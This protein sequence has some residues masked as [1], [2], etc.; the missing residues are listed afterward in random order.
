[1]P[2]RRY[3]RSKGNSGSGKDGA[4]AKK[5]ALATSMAWAGTGIKVNTLTGE[6]AFDPTVPIDQPGEEGDDALIWADVPEALRKRLMQKPQQVTEDCLMCNAKGILRLYEN[7][8][9]QHVIKQQLRGEQL[10]SL[11]RRQ[12]AYRDEGADSELRATSGKLA[13]SSFLGQDPTGE[14]PIPDSLWEDEDELSEKGALLKDVQDTV[15]NYLR[16]HLTRI[17]SKDVLARVQAQEEMYRNFP[18]MKEG[19]HNNRMPWSEYKQL[20]TY[21]LPRDTG[22]YVLAKVLTMV[23]EDAESAQSWAQRMHK[24]RRRVSKRMQTNLSDACYRELLFQGLTKKEQGELVK[25]QI[26]R[27]QLH[28]HEV[29]D[30]VMA[31]WS[32]LGTY[33]LAEI[34][35]VGEDGKIDVRYASAYE[36]VELGLE[37]DDIRSIGK[38]LA[39]ARAMNT[40]RSAPWVML[41]K[42]VYNDIGPQPNYIARTRRGAHLLFTHEQALLLGIEILLHSLP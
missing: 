7:D 31:N 30:Q 15:W 24:G 16:V 5:P 26:Q 35:A 39:K 21:L 9:T 38:S 34:T 8:I 37:V 1:M 42:Y 19:L 22:M 40:L 6:G 14:R 18:L 4:K 32:G 17:L 27:A 36:D 23:R 11:I 33:Y 13:K 25:A 20:I 10:S 12:G 28:K 41:V 2:K 29:G 3:A